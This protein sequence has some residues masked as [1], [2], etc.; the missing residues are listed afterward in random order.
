MHT[1]L[2]I[3]RS[4][5]Q[6]GEKIQ[7]LRAGVWVGGGGRKLPSR[8]DIPEGVTYKHST[9]VEVICHRRGERA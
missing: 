2:L 1:I 5:Q 3:L 7:S 4:M 9:E 6:V 8:G